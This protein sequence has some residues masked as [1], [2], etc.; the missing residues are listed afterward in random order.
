MVP[1]STRTAGLGGN[2]AKATSVDTERA[3]GVGVTTGLVAAV[4]TATA[5]FFWSA[6]ISRLLESTYACGYND[7]DLNC[8]IVRIPE[9]AKK[10]K[11]NIAS[12][13]N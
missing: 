10:C 3:A 5:S 6:D 11:A 12:H 4:P 13:L 7:S 2:A 8:L 9:L 1:Y